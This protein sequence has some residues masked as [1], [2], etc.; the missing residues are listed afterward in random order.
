VNRLPKSAVTSAELGA[1]AASTAAVFATVATGAT[2][3]G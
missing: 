3:A 1:P 2:W